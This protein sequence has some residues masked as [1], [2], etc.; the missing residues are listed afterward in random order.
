MLQLTRTKACWFCTVNFAVPRRC[1]RN[2]PSRARAPHALGVTVLPVP[3]ISRP[4]PLPSRWYS[5]TPCL[6][7]RRPT[8]HRQAR[9]GTPGSDPQTERSKP[10]GTVPGPSHS[11]IQN[12][13][14]LQVQSSSRI[15]RVLFKLYEIRRAGYIACSGRGDLT[16]ARAEYMIWL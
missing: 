10:T 3:S 4:P 11:T 12:W 15:A 14:W 9:Q 7:A 2:G 8:S 16:P 1:N 5:G 6:G 13:H